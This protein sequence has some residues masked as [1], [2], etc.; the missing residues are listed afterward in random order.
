MDPE[1]HS[2]STKEAFESIVDI[3]KFEDSGNDQKRA[4][5]R[6]KG[7]TVRQPTG[8]SSMRQLSLEPGAP[9]MPSVTEEA[10]RTSSPT[11]TSPLTLLDVGLGG[12]DSHGP[13]DSYSDIFETQDPQQT[14]H[15]PQIMTPGQIEVPKCR[16][17]K[18]LQTPSPGP[19][20]KSKGKTPQRYQEPVTPTTPYL[21]RRKQ[22]EIEESIEKHKRIETSSSPEQSSG[23]S[24]GD[25]LFSPYTSGT[26]LKADPKASSSSTVY[27]KKKRRV[28]AT[29]ITLDEVELR[30]AGVSEAE[31][32]RAR[33]RIA[34]RRSRERKNQRIC[35]LEEENERLQMEIDRLVKEAI[36][37]ATAQKH[38]PKKS[39][40]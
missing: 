36:E 2:D 37:A 11:E 26:M 24:E 10:I 16:Y 23:S 19:Q 6:F 32:K 13:E 4:K 8:T 31:I 14:P 18:R 28:S 29:S 39:K 5:E 15:L 21:T 35:E 3:S 40:S 38:G 1:E 22:R 34:A 12:F 7:L 27:R 25:D 20:T 30:K 9:W 33:N 17:L